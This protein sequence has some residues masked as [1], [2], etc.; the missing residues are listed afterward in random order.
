MVLTF[1]LFGA[2]STLA[3]I[4]LSITAIAVHVLGLGVFLTFY[5]SN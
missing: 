4:S 5:S 2:K 1:F 3:L